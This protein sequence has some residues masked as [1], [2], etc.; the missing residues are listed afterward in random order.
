MNNKGGY[1][2]VDLEELILDGVENTLSGISGKIGKVYELNKPVVITNLKLKKALTGLSADV[3]I[4]VANA[5][6]VIANGVYVITTMI[7]SMNININVNKTN[8]KYQGIK[9]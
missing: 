8:N 7:A 4:P 6:L 1:I 2:L 9:F 3:I 5:T